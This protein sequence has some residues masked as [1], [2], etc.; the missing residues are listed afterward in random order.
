MKK[1]I[2]STL[3]LFLIFSL[4]IK[5]QEQK[6]NLSE[7]KSRK[8]CVEIGLS[9]Y[10]QGDN[11]SMFGGGGSIAYYFT[12]KSR[13]SL[14]INAYG[15]DKEID[16]FSY[17]I[18]TTT[19][20]VVTNVEHRDDGVITRSYMAIPSLITWSYEFNY[21][22]KLNFRIG[23]S[24]GATTLSLSDSYD[25]SNVNGMP[26]PETIDDGVFTFGISAGASL[27][28]FKNSGLNFG[29]KLLGNSEKSIEE[30]KIK[31][32]TCQI[33]LYYFYRF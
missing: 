12:P 1:L 20:G 26:E 6:T 13:L 18:T 33:G 24:I 7:T 21:S 27:L 23:P 31:P 17:T 22:E 4:S 16:K 25:P 11:S 9:G 19:N 2:L 3:I 5:A 28:L 15:R 8:W 32:F 29:I 30:I 14:D 10:L